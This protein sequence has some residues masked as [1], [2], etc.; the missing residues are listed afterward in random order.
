VRTPPRASWLILA[1]FVAGGVAMTAWEPTR[2]LLIGPAWLAGSLSVALFYAAMGAKARRLDRLR[3]NGEP[4]RA[5]ATAVRE[6]GLVVHEMPRI[7]LELDVHSPAG[8]RAVTHRTVAPLDALEA[9][10]AGEEFEVRVDPGSDRLAFL[11]PETSGPAASLI[12]RALGGPARIDSAA[13][14]E[15]SRHLESPR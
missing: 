9:L 8:A 7:E 12:S 3:R 2:S 14:R 6:L 10:K 1:L 11:W 15:E 4:G 5:R 13:L